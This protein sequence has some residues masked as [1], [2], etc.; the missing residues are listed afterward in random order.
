MKF[1]SQIRFL[2][3]KKGRGIQELPWTPRDRH[4]TQRASLAQTLEKLRENLR[5][6][7]KGKDDVIE[8]AI[9]ALICGE[10]MLIEDV[11]GVGKTTLAKSLAASVHLDFQRVQ[12]T[13][14]LLPADIFGFSVFNPQDGSFLRNDSYKIWW[15]PLNCGPTHLGL[16]FGPPFGTVN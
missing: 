12:C 14:D 11:P 13:P 6:V 16:H 5:Q 1:R 10:S 4:F 7:I 8:H 3:C 15:D 9:L 2:P